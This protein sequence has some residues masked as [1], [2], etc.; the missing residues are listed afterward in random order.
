MADHV[1]W[2]VF[3]LTKDANIGVIDGN[4]GSKVW[5]QLMQSEKELKVISMY[6]LEGSDF[7]S[8]VSGEKDLF[9]SSKNNETKSEPAQSVSCGT[10]NLEQRTH[11]ILLLLCCE[12]V[13]YLHSLKS[14]EEV[15]FSKPFELQHL[16]ISA[17]K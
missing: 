14:L 6:I 8:E 1:K 16:G 3:I 15:L 9:D 7:I 2:Q 17:F 4:T 5:S 12:D 11:N 13:L 10:T